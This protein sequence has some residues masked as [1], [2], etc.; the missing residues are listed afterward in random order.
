LLKI[1]DKIVPNLYT[2]S[3]VDRPQNYQRL[4]ENVDNY[5]YTGTWYNPLSYIPISA[6]IGYW[7]SKRAIKKI[8]TTIKKWK[9]ENIV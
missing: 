5:E 6:H 1:Y 4:H 3:S 9:E 2:A 7:K 8:K